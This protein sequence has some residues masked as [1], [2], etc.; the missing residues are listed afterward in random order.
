MALRLGLIGDHV[1][2]K[3]LALALAQEGHTVCWF[4][5]AAVVSTLMPTAQPLTH[6][7]LPATCRHVLPVQVSTTHGVWLL[8][9]E[10]T[11]WEDAGLHTRLFTLL[12]LWHRVQPWHVLQAGSPLA[13]AYLTVYTARFLGVPAAVWVDE[14]LLAARTVQ[15]FRW[16]WITRH[17]AALLGSGAPAGGP[18][19][20]ALDLA[21]P[22][23][24]SQM[25]ALYGR[26]GVGG[27]EPRGRDVIPGSV[28]GS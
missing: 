19:V 1:A 14:T 25:T 17:A 27:I 21:C 28:P 12:G 3:P 9:L 7:H 26:L 4:L 2:L 18:V 23:L 24:G 16:E 8:G 22:D 11:L 6:E 15:P 10:Q 5:P 20:Q 13:L